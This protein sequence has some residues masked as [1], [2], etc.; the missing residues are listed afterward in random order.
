VCWSRAIAGTLIFSNEAS[1]IMWGLGRGLQRLGVLPEKLVWDREAAIHGHGGRPTEAFA[2][3]CGQL[4]V[5]WIIL[6]AHV[7]LPM[8][9]RGLSRLRSTMSHQGQ[10]C[11]FHPIVALAGALPDL[12]TDL[13][14]QL[15]ACSSH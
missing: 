1:D 3:F 7:I 15:E 8:P 4:E 10:A 5:G 11:E 6:E 9:C 13:I 12:P 14:R 2:S